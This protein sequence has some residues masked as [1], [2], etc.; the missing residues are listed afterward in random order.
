M[1]NRVEGI[2]SVPTA[3]LLAP[4]TMKNRFKNAFI[5]SRRFWRKHQ[6][7][8]FYKQNFLEVAIIFLQYCYFLMIYLIHK[9]VSLFKS[10]VLS[11]HYF[12]NKERNVAHGEKM[13]SS[14]IIYNTDLRC[15]FGYFSDCLSTETVRSS[16]VISTFKELLI[17]VSLI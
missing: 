1:T 4:R 10:R 17:C 12:I 13:F 3:I 6:I 15:K 7:L 14:V 16:V 9:N 8:Q 5:F 2:Y 11:T